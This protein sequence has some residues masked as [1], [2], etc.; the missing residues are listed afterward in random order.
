MRKTVLARNE[1]GKAIGQSIYSGSWFCMG[2]F[3]GPDNIKTRV[4]VWYGETVKGRMAESERCKI[5]GMGKLW[6]AQG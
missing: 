5:I 3:I 4:N 6:K 1:S 2:A